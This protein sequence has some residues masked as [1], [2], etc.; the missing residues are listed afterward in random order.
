VKQ[1]YHLELERVVEEIKGR[2]V[3]RVLLQL[4][5]GL[6]PL[7]FQMVKA[8]RESTGAQVFLSGDSCYGAC[9]LAVN[10]ARELSVGLVVHYG[11]SR[12]AEDG[13]V[14]VLYVHAEV[15]LDARAL[16][17]EAAPHLS[18]WRRIGLVTT[19]QHV[20]MVD[21]IRGE[22]RGRGFTVYVGEGGERAPHPGQVLGCYYGNA[23]AVAGDVEAYLYVGGGE[24]HP[25][26]L[27]LSTGKPV[28]VANPFTATVS[29]MTEDDLMQLAKKRVAQI[30]AT[31]DAER[32][33][34]LVSSKPGQRATM[35]AETLQSRFAAKGYEAVIIYLD[36]VRAEH[37]NNFVEAQAFVNTAC[38]RVAV[39]GVSGVDRP[40][41]TVL[42][43]EVVLGDRLWEDIWGD[44]YL[45]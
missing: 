20:H 15:D 17:E 45:G 11:H 8:L 27:I 38:P 42:E 24:F 39:D 36:E 28:V 34:V 6:R 19:V 31:R 13:D 29:L 22:L 37:L 10:Q 7:A 16:V 26:G 30:A 23:Q 32:I 21:E 35:A 44:G 2:G 3:D 1:L 25:K 41:L 4:P 18:R 9:D 5:D 40:I 43:A 12:M 33:G 14:P